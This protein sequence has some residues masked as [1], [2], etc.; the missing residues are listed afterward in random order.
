MLIL[1]HVNVKVIQA[2]AEVAGTEEDINAE[3]THN[4]KQ[5]AFVDMNV[6]RPPPFVFE[7]CSSV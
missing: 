6:L 3:G 2:G 5:V 7:T 4:K 1:W